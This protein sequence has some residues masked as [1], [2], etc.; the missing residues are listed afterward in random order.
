MQQL[1]ETLTQAQRK[2]PALEKLANNLLQLAKTTSDKLSK[3]NDTQGT[4]RHNLPL[5]A[6]D[7]VRLLAEKAKA[8][9][10]PDA[11]QGLPTMIKATLQSLK[12]MYGHSYLNTSELTQPPSQERLNN[13]AKVSEHFPLRTWVG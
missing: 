1:T 4:L 13:L 2:T 3:L 8:T 12:T 5:E 9:L 10:P 11:Q 7:K 6:A